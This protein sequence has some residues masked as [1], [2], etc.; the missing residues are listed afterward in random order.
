MRLAAPSHY[1]TVNNSIHSNSNK[2]N[3][4]IN[5]NNNYNTDKNLLKIKILFT[6]KLFHGSYIHVKPNRQVKNNA[7]GISFNTHNKF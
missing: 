5:N 4:I 2:D 3:N 7:K 1:I 6:T